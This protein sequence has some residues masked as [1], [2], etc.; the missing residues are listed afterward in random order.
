M[1]WFISICYILAVYGITNL[2][3]FGT[4]PFYILEKW[5]NFAFRVSDNFGK[6][7]TCFMCLPA[8]IG[9]LSSLVNWFL[10]PEIRF[11][12]FNIIFENTN[13]W[14][15]AMILDMGIVSGCCWLIYVIDD[16]FEKKTQFF[17]DNTKYIDEDR[18]DKIILND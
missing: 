9:W 4:G 14:W 3:A 13:L 1:C 11:T 17:E 16:Y 7:F 2:F 18:D 10:F 6:L 15:L 5:R 8:N 12:P